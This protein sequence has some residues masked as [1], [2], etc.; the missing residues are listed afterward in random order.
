VISSPLEATVLTAEQRAAF[1]G[2][3]ERQFGIR[4][5]DYGAGRMDEAVSTVLPTT[6]CT[7]PDEL[8]A[9]LETD[10][11][12]RWLHA[13]VEHLT[14]GETYFLRNPAQ[15]AAL[16]ETILPDLIERRSGEQ[17]LRL[18]SAG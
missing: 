1:L 3:V 12:P 2:L 14:V 5:S 8:L 18:W 7:T 9:N 4:G 17:R 13:L 15:I 6:T 10:S 11:Q 16:R